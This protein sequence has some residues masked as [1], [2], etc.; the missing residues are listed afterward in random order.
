MLLFFDSLVSCNRAATSDDSLNVN[1]QSNQ[2]VENTFHIRASLQPFSPPSSLNGACWGERMN[3]S[4]VLLLGAKSA[5][6][7]REPSAGARWQLGE[8]VPSQASA[9]PRSEPSGRRRRRCHSGLDTGTR[10]L[11]IGRRPPAAASLT[12]V[13]A[14]E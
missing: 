13:T 3:P 7:G 14:R 11:S 1:I 12:L 4:P 9:A 6:R 5:R 8:R 2:P 10:D